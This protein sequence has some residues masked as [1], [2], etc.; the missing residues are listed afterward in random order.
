MM[1][2]FADL[3]VVFGLP[4]MLQTQKTNG[5]LRIQ[6][7]YFRAVTLYLPFTF[8]YS[9]NTKMTDIYVFGY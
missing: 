7:N 9:Y 1:A 6:E 4:V 8:H 2:I 3:R 5:K